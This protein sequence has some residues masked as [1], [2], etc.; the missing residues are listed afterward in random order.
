[1]EVILNGILSGLILALLIGPVFF[2]IIQTSIERGFA[3][4]A[5]VAVGVSVSDAMYISLAYL[6]IYRLFDDGLA[7]EYL[8]YFGGAV[9]LLFAAYY[10]F[11]KSR[12][13]LK[14]PPAP[15]SNDPWRL[16][17]KGFVINGLSPMVLIFWLG[18]V[19]VATSKLGYTEPSEAGPYFVAIVVTVFGTDLIKAKLADK[20]REM[21]T[22]RF[23]RM[24]NLALGL[25]MLIFGIR[26][27]I[28]AGVQ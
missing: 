19:G 17:G 21:L 8:G 20:L 14:G 2:T 22:H 23:V 18:T 16:V 6:G 4:G 13:L 28:Y 9:L 5:F 25:V 26:L 11:V 10:L 12:K 1:M 3:S 24:L 27:I 15:A 7:R